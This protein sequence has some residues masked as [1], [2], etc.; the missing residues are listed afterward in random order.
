MPF[1]ELVFEGSL[2]MIAR[3]TVLFFYGRK[4]TSIDP[5]FWQNIHPFFQKWVSKFAQFKNFW[6][7]VP[8]WACLLGYMFN[9]PVQN[10]HQLS[11][12]LPG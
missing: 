1:L 9:D 8:R 5:I 10:C 12:N 11:P 3:T 7:R 4:I 2:R 6:W